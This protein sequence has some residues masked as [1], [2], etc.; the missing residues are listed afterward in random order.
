MLSLFISIN[1]HNL[2]L[3]QRNL[4]LVV[5]IADL[6]NNKDDY[7]PYDGEPF[8]IVSYTWVDRRGDILDFLKNK[9]PKK[10][11]QQDQRN[12]AFSLLLPS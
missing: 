1:F 6:E 5:R 9:S 10:Q 4:E 11:C 7:V 8:E 2:S 3:G 12:S